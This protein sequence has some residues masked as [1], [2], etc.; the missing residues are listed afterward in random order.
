MFLRLLG[1]DSAWQNPS[2]IYD[3]D[4]NKSIDPLDVL[5][6][7]NYINLKGSGSLP[8]TRPSNSLYGYVDVDGDMQVSPLDV[9]RVI[10]M[11][12]ATRN[13]EGEATQECSQRQEGQFSDF[14]NFSMESIDFSD[15]QPLKKIQNRAYLLVSKRQYQ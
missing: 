15:M 4:D 2:Q 1:A 11:I 3:V 14:L 8:G 7:I 9:L 10:N 13:G 12:N 5:N 6:L